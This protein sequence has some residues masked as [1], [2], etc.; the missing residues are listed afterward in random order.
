MSGCQAEGAGR[1]SR[2][3]RR[4]LVA[5]LWGPQL[6]APTADTKVSA[7]QGP[8]GQQGCHS[9]GANY[10]GDQALLLG[11]GVVEDW[12][13]EKILEPALGV[14]SQRQHGV[15]RHHLHSVV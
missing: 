7:L 6:P 15:G 2:R 10:W 4:S 13:E 8:G 3:D 1:S 9:V 12:M 5:D 11:W 14:G